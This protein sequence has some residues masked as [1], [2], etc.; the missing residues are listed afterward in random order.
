M[1]FSS[2]LRHR[3][4]IF[5]PATGEDALGQPN[6]GRVLFATR[7]A[8]IATTGGLETIKAGAVTSKVQSSIR[9]RYCTDLRAD[10]EVDHG[11]TTYK[12]LAVLP[13][14]RTK[15]YVDLVCEILQ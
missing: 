3:V 6:I 5:A 13:D 4:T 12:V 10:M 11:M 9:L 7:W 15:R 14:E 8:D 2:S 1:T